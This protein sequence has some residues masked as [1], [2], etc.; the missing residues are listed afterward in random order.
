MGGFKCR[1]G[2]NQ[3]TEVLIDNQPYFDLYERRT[4][5]NLFLAHQQ[6]L[7]WYDFYSGST[8]GLTV[9]HFE[10]WVR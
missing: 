8:F 4:T 2:M 7:I 3:H 5:K 9:V 6:I 10:V 1:F